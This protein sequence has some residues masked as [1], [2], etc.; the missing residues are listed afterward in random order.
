[1]ATK[2]DRQEGMCRDGSL[3]PKPSDQ[4]ERQP[5]AGD[6]TTRD[7]PIGTPIGIHDRVGGGRCCCTQD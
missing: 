3:V 6:E 7:G 4:N 5:K 1:M 2:A